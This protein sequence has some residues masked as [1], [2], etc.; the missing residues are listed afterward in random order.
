MKIGLLQAAADAK[1][2]LKAFMRKSTK[3]RSVLDADVLLQHKRKKSNKQQQFTRYEPGQFEV[4]PESVLG[5]V[6][7]SKRKS[8][9][10]PK[11][12]EGGLRD[13]LAE[14]SVPL[15]TKASTHRGTTPRPEDDTENHAQ[16]NI[17][18]VTFNKRTSRG[19]N[20]TEERDNHKEALQANERILNATSF[21]TDL[22]LPGREETMKP[23]T[24]KVGAGKKNR[25]EQSTIWNHE[26]LTIDEPRP[27]RRGDR[28][29]ERVFKTLPES[30]RISE[31]DR[32]QRRE[33]Q[34]TG[35][36]ELGTGNGAQG[37]V[38]G[39]KHDGDLEEGNGGEA[40]GTR[41]SPFF[42]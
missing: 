33:E 26:D 2:K 16:D 39:D 21:A 4:K 34:G 10:K 37:E 38:E 42:K 13:L 3:K 14:P 22:E 32:P 30:K 20:T 17:P 35:K 28:E 29:K 23:V 25:E 6:L 31:V 15:G 27:S 18:N 7:K 8:E 19:K 36:Q 40:E 24:R 12:R 5:K 1:E 11:L 9:E 41:S